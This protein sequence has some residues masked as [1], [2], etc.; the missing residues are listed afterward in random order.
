VTQTPDKVRVVRAMLDAS[1]PRCGADREHP[2]ERPDGES[3]RDTY[4]HLD[5]MVRAGVR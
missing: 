3:Y 4:A 2:C 1:C 5:R